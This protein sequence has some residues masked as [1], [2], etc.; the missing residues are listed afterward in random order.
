[1]GELRDRAIRAGVHDNAYEIIIAN[2][3]NKDI[4]SHE[5]VDKIL[6]I[7]ELAIM[8]REAE[9]PTYWQGE[10]MPYQ[11]RNKLVEDGWLKE[12]KE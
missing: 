5:L 6:S 2:R 10:H 4:G 9:L 1:M 3:C 12:V 7:P 8:D 11:M